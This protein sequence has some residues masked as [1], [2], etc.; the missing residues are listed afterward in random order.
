MR[1]PKKSD[2][3]LFNHRPRRHSRPD[4]EPHKSTNHAHSL[5]MPPAKRTLGHAVSRYEKV[6]LAA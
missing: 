2:F 3:R 5:A 6:K 1:T 4:A